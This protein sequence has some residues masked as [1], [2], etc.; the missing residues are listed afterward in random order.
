MTASTPSSLLCWVVHP[1]V[2]YTSK[3]WRTRYSKFVGD[4]RIRSGGAVGV[5]RE[6]LG[7]ADEF[8]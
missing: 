3:I 7:L 4:M 8:A 2:P 6:Y 5:F 1:L